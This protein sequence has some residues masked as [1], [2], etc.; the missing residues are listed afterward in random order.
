MEKRLTLRKK[1]GIV[2]FKKR[3]RRETTAFSF[4]EGREKKGRSSFSMGEESCAVCQERA[5]QLL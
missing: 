4:P 3:I 2:A 5:F 1:K